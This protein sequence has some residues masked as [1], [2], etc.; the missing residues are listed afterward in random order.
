MCKRNSRRRHRF[1]LRWESKEGRR[2]SIWI[3]ENGGRI[4]EVERSMKEDVYEQRR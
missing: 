1:N 3:F 2:L 4:K